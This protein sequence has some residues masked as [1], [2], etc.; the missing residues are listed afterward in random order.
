MT[1]D[2]NSIV[3]SPTDLTDFTACRH[4]TSLEMRR[5]KEE[6][7]RPYNA[8]PILEQIR[9]RGMDFEKQYVEH[10][11]AKH[12]NVIDLTNKSFDETVAAM[13]EGADVIVQA[14]LT[15]KGWTGKADILIKVAR[16]SQL[17]NWSYEVQDTK[18]SQNTR[19]S[20]VL[21]LCFYSEV[22]GKIQGTTPELMK[23]IKPGNP[24]KEDE[25]RFDDF[26]SYFNTIKRN[27]ED[28]TAKPTG[29][30]PDPVEHCKIC[31]WWNVC[32]GKRRED[33]HLSL[34][35]GIRA[36]QTE[37]L[38]HQG[39]KTMEIFASAEKINKPERGNVKNLENKQKQAKLQVSR[40][41]TNNLTCEFIP[42]KSAKKNNPDEPDDH[43]FYLLPERNDGDI[44]FDFEGDPFFEG[45]GIEYLFGFIYKGSGNKWVYEKYWIKNRQE[46]K[47]AF[48]KFMAFV[49][50]RLPSFPELCIYHYS[51][52]EATSFKRLM[53]EH[54]CYEDE[55]NKLLRGLRF[56][57]LRSVFKKAIRAGVEQYSLKDLEK[58]AKFERQIA[59]EKAGP[60]RREVELAI[61]SGNYAKLT[62]ELMEFVNQYNE[63]DCRATL[64]LHE[65]I[66]SKRKEFEKAGNE[67]KRLEINNGELEDENQKQKRQDLKNLSDKLMEGLPDR[68]LWQPE[69]R[70]KVLLANI[71]FYFQREIESSYWELYATLGKDE[72]DLEDARNAINGL[73]FQ[74]ALPLKGKEVNPTEVY[75]F[76]DQEISAKTN[77]EVYDFET[78]K[79]IGNIEEI[80]LTDHTIFVKRKGKNKEIRP[81]NIVFRETGVNSDTLVKSLIELAQYVIQNGLTRDGSF[82]AAIDLLCKNKPVFIQE[83][84]PPFSNFTKQGLVDS[85]IQLSKLLNNSVLAL[86]GPPGTGK[87]HTGAEMILALL[88]AKKKI[89]VT[90]VS[91]KAYQN[92]ML[93]VKELAA[94][95][96]IEVKLAIDK[97]K[98][99]EGN[100]NFSLFD[101]KKKE[102]VEKILKDGFVL[103][104]TAWLWASDKSQQQLDYLFVDEAGQMSL[105]Y[106]L[107][108]AKSTKNL[109][110]LGDPNQLEQPQ[111]GTHPE[112]SDVAALAHLL[113]GHKTM[114]DDRGIL[115]HTTWRLHPDICRFTSEQFYESKLHSA[116]GLEKQIIT[117]NSKFGG[118]GLFFVPVTHKGNQTQSPEEVEAIKSI[119]SDLMSKASYNGKRISNKDIVIVAPYNSQ[120]NA[121]KLALPEFR[122]GTVDKFQGQEA[123]VVIYSMTSSSVEDTPR[124]MGFLFDPNRFNV[125]TSRALSVCILVASPKLFEADCNTIEQMRWV[126]VLCRYKE[127][128]MVHFS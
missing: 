29:T 128:A 101:F 68:S 120:V 63:D 78:R 127:M 33:D 119:V 124:G 114:P 70:T 90:A 43:G 1:A 85:A 77:S 110:L 80:N 17:G 2:N 44:Y 25:Y 55:V 91:H 107:A 115:M 81:A 47:T 6:I 123:P 56:V 89:G 51:H 69:H 108:I 41:Q 37:E 22:V 92:L 67:L 45:G 50:K 102:D 9:L 19:N 16:P 42:L 126:N 99:K 60:A 71:L 62:D 61:N 39:L 100:D 105:A 86:Q 53:R 65:W 32:A 35:A 74:E 57:D 82:S 104:D 103:G 4:L 109:V 11:K 66:E 52:K 118:S 40:R 27:L 23:I 59:L 96:G 15:S 8:D 75:L 98:A 7:D 34:V 83:V 31:N 117:G 24:F 20:A 64:A 13:K 93:K 46:E 72:E 76:D 73:V 94:K 3:L 106:V 54:G 111:K 10:L 121:L 84:V 88:F 21:Q 113:D 87:T 14:R 125:A 28:F 26:K 79:L 49:A 112:G 18:L 95:K 38:I 12:G 58:F 122:I 36:S 5:V 97:K 116:D 48:Q 30:Y